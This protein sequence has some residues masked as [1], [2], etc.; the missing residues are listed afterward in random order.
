MMPEPHERFTI[1]ADRPFLV[2]IRDDGTG[3][4]LFLGV[5]HDP[6]Q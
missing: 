2:A 3:A 5:V 6:K 1:K 4:L